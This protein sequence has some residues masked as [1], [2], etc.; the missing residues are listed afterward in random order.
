MRT[1]KRVGVT[2]SFLVLAAAAIA[3]LAPGGSSES[4]S[5]AAAGS[6]ISSPGT[7]GMRVYLDPETGDVSSEVDPNAVIELDAELENALRHD[8]EGLETVRH[9]DGAESLNLE[10]RYQEAS[11]VR[12]DA[13]GKAVICT[14]NVA[15]L[16]KTLTD[17]TPV[18]PEVK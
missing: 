3:V 2:I 4:K 12:I 9:A 10:G 5:V 17:T 16:E 7:A 1:S 13:N 8:S 15:N 14:D 11:V 6:G 18:S